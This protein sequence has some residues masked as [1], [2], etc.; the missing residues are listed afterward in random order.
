[1]GAYGNLMDETS[2]KKGQDQ[3]GPVARYFRRHSLGTAAWLVNVAVAASEGMAAPSRRLYTAQGRL[4]PPGSAGATGDFIATSLLGR[5]GC[6]PTPLP[7][8][9]VP[10]QPARVGGSRPVTKQFGVLIIARIAIGER[11]ECRTLAMSEGP[12][13]SG[14]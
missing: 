8:A 3:T 12:S 10:D 5:S 2:W 1:M 4:T 6:D 14:T 13:S 7:T 9:W 11:N